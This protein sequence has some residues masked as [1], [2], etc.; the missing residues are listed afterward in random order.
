MTI[1][2]IIAGIVAFLLFLYNQQISFPV[3][4]EYID[5]SLN[6][7]KIIVYYNGEPHDVTQFV[8]EHPGG[9]EI[10]VH[11]NGQEI[12]KLMEGNGHSEHAY[13]ILDEFRL[14]KV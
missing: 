2:F 12:K 5:H 9:T 4:H 14:T 13:K 3:S 8:D 7:Q 11:H 10:L 1:G 6:P